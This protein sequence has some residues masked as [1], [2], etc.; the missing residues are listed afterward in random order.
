MSEALL[1]LLVALAI[2]V[3][4]IGVVVPVLPGTVLVLG[5]LFVWALVTGGAAAWS[6]FAVMTLIIVLGQVLKYLLPG[7]SMTAA[8]VP[9]RSVMIGGLAAIAGFFLIPV[10]GLIVG[11]VGGVYVAEH[12]RLGDW[13]ASRES[14]L[15]AMRA[16][17]L[18]ILI[19]LAAVLLAASVW[20]GTALIVT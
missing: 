4:I 10:V 1:N 20:A 14:T 8:G 5:A 12:L 9:G 2:I 17:G 16:T 6:A 13:T 7:R 18:S 11:F 15:V 19:E 3:G